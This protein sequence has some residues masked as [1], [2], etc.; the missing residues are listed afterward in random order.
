M[1]AMLVILAAVLLIAIFGFAVTGYDF[2]MFKFWA[3]KYEN[4]RREVFVNTQSFVQ[5]KIE[6]LTRL[7]FEYQGAEGAQKVALRE[8]ILS[9]AAQVDGDKLPADLL[10]FIRQV[11]QAQ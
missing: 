9:E 2:A 3:P 4:V 8:L 11:R 6:Y 10:S 5:G 7:R 1:K